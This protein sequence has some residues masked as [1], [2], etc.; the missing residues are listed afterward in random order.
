MGIRAVGVWARVGSWVCAVV[1]IWWVR[2]WMVSCI[3][4]GVADG[5][6]KVFIRAVRAGVEGTS[7]MGAGPLESVVSVILVDC[8]SARGIGEDLGLGW[9][10]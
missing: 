9:I 7:I 8:V 6:Q 2:V 4:F 3:I 5:S 1:R 10:F